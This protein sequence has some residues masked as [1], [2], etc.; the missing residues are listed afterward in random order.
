[1]LLWSASLPHAPS[2]KLFAGLFLHLAI[3]MELLFVGEAVREVD[4]LA[5]EVCLHE[6]WVDGVIVFFPEVSENVGEVDVLFLH[7]L[8]VAPA[9][10]SLSRPNEKL[11]RL[12][13]LVSTSHMAVDKVLV[14]NLQKPMI[15]LVLFRHPMPVVELLRLF[16]T[17]LP[18]S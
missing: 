15:S 7:F 10:F 13:D 3:S 12:E 1:M 4:F 17:H 11:H 9:L 6:R 18:T 2:S 5:F 16:F 8:V 14:V